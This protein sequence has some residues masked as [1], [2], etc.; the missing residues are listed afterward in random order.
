MHGGYFISVLFA[1]SLTTGGAKIM[2]TNGN[3]RLGQ[4]AT[5]SMKYIII[6]L[7]CFYRL[8]VFIYI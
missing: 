4:L 7:Q 6:R 1:G 3:K 2:F 8:K 5:F